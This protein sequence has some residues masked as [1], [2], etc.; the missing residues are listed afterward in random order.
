MSKQDRITHAVNLWAQ[1]DRPYWKYIRAQ[2][3]DE[4]LMEIY[5]ASPR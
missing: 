5:G 1:E 3:L 2:V 4:A